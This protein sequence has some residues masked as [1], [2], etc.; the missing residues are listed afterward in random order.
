MWV[1]VV[2][3]CYGVMSAVPFLQFYVLS[4]FTDTAKFYKSHSIV[5]EVWMLSSQALYVALDSLLAGGACWLALRR[6]R[7]ATPLVMELLA[8]WKIIGALFGIGVVCFLPLYFGTWAG[9]VWFTHRL[10]PR[11]LFDPIWESIAC[12]AFTFV[13]GFATLPLALAP[14]FAIDQNMS[15][16]GSIK[17]SCKVLLPKF[18]QVFLLLNLAYLASR[19]GVIL[20]GI[21]LLFTIPIYWLTLAMVYDQAT[22]QVT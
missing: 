11:P 17:A 16:I 8:G 10:V 1:L 7:G 9:H 5:R 2:I 3:V 22:S 15:L 4:L 21:G 13:F 14:L 20:C 19:S 18:G 12:M 6:V